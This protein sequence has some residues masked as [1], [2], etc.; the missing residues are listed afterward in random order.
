MCSWLEKI[1]KGKQIFEDKDTKLFKKKN[2]LN[3]H[4]YIYVSKH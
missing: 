1:K 3:T 2:P 4:T